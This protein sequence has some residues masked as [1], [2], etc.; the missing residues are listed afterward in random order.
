MIRTNSDKLDPD[1]RAKA[2]IRSFHPRCPFDS[3]SG[4]IRTV[5]TGPMEN[6]KPSSRASSNIHLIR[7]LQSWPDILIRTFT[8]IRT[9][10]SK[11]LHHYQ[12]FSAASATVPTVRNGSKVR[13]KRSQQTTG[14]EHKSESNAQ[15]KLPDSD[16]SQDQKAH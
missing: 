9:T 5:A 12:F 8:L 14:L 3:D 10:K 2:L 11:P 15:S 4:A 7:T 1:Y 13:I 6:K 16:K